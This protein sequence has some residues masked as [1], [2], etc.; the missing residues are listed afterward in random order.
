MTMCIKGLLAAASLSTIALPYAPAQAQTKLLLSV[1][2]ITTT[3]ECHLYQG[4]SGSLSTHSQSAAGVY[5]DRHGVGAIAASESDAT[6]N[7]T[8]FFYKDCANHFEGIRIAMQSALASSGE[9]TVGG[10]GL[11]L[12]G[13]LENVVTTGSQFQDQSI[14][15][16]RYG[17]NNS[18]ML[19]TFNV[20]VA[21]RAGRIV[22]GAPV[23]TE[24]ETGSA[25]GSRGT[26]AS[27]SIS[28][29]G[30]YA[31][32]Q[33][34]V[35]KAAA[36]AVAFHFRPMQVVNNSGQNIQLNY[37]AP[38]LEVGQIVSVTSPDGSASMRY[39]ISSVG[40]QTA[41]AQMQGGGGDDSRIVPGSRAAV[42]ESGDPA[43]REGMQRVELP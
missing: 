22:F 29:E 13:R 4:T 2:P 10:G 30:V 32:L 11:V 3:Q 38:L 7:W 21:D 37:G 9:V 26:Y 1:A 33:Q 5:S 34:Q 8:T 24:I 31:V 16:N 43:L 28:G 23:S 27:S 19:V 18:G 42:L 39:R 6:L 35:A 25:V 40:E 12:K 20:T 17:V 36:R 41:L 15:G 14:T